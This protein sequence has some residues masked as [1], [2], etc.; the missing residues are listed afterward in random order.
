MAQFTFELLILN[1]YTGVDWELF[2]K[3][4]EGELKSI[5]IQQATIRALQV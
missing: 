4:C 1:F 5:A 2:G 3:R